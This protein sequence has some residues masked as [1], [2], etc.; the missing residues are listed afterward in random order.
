MKRN[1]MNIVNFV[2]GS[3][4][5]G[6]MDLYTPVEKQIK[7]N[8]KYGLKST[9]LLQYDAMQREDFRK[10]FLS[11]AADDIELGVW[12]ENCRELIESIGLK[13]EGREGYDWDWYVNPGF[14]MA[15]TNEEREKIVDAVFLKFK[16]IFGKYP[17][18]AGSWIL[19]AYSM[20]Y[21]CEK[22]GMKAFCNCREQWAVDAYSLWGGYINGGYYASKKNMLCPSQTEENKISAP[23][24]RM[25]TIDPI[26]GYDCR[27]YNDKFENGFNCWTLEPVW[28]EGQEPD[29]IKWMFNEYYRNPKVSYAHGTTGQENS[30]G[31]ENFGKGYVLQAEILYALQKEGVVAVETLGES[32]ERFK[33]EYKENPPYTLSAMTDW[34]GNDYKTTWYN[35]KHYRADLFKRGDALL[36]RGINKFDENYEERYLTK[37]CKEWCARYDNL[38]VLD[39]RLW[40]KNGKDCYLKFNKKVDDISIRETGNN[41]F[42]ADIT[43]ADK[44]KGKVVFEED[45]IKIVGDVGLSLR[46]GDCGD[47]IEYFLDGN[48]F[49]FKHNG[50][51]YSVR[52]DAKIEKSGEVFVLSPENDEII[53]NF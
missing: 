8:R 34:C 41:S 26:Y 33:E 48:V 51:N 38:P 50:F 21:M 24:F 46:F 36:F 28:K 18:V 5:R 12:F 53:I 35:S 15:Y 20:N 6:P 45:F 4:P 37:P 29:I 44:K 10:L 16:E 7:T 52:V 19:D 49:N 11:N 3:E 9:F 17:Q 13:W 30:F 43:W 42:I 32:G 23:M 47:D 14:L 25:L 22:Y 31:W 40:S 1:V 27:K 2:R 39:T